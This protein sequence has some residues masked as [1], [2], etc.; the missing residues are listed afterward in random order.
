MLYQCHKRKAKF[1]ALRSTWQQENREKRNIKCQPTVPHLSCIK[2]LPQQSHDEH[3]CSATIQPRRRQRWHSSTQGSERPPKHR[4]E[5]GSAC[6]RQI[7]ALFATLARKGSSSLVT[8]GI[9]G[10]GGRSESG[11]LPFRA[12]KSEKGCEAE[13]RGRGFEMLDLPTALE[14]LGPEAGADEA[15]QLELENEGF[16]A[17]AWLR[18]ALRLP[19]LY[20]LVVPKEEVSALRCLYLDE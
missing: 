9:C 4:N 11:A 19:R 2:T 1:I 13:R 18:S 12:P 17:R 7:F 20:F 16:T 14:W 15:V 3:P 8:A 10:E 6:T 5:S